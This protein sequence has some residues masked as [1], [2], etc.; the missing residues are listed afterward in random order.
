MR[1]LNYASLVLLLMTM[2]T[3]GACGDD[4]YYTDD[5][6]RNSDEK[7]CGKLWVDAYRINDMDSCTHILYFR[8]D[9]KGTETHKYRKIN[10]DG[11]VSDYYKEVSENFYWE[12]IDNKMEGLKMD[13]IQKGIL[14]FDNVWVRDNY[15]SGKFRGEMITFKKE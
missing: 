4:V 10:S 12:W 11:T 6:L 1:K 15:L 5:F 14:Y 8:N 9:Y 3:L 13:Y 2:L 7:L